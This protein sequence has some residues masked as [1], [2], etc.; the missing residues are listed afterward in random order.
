MLSLTTGP[1]NNLSVGE[2]W[3]TDLLKISITDYSGKW[4]TVLIKGF[5]LDN[6]DHFVKHLV[7]IRPKKEI[8]KYYAVNTGTF[9]FNFEAE[10]FTGLKISVWGGN[11]T[12]NTEL[13]LFYIG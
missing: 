7:N 13:P 10:D 2:G 8:T 12:H 4:R 11:S 9:K 5:D 1:I 6:Q 3:Q